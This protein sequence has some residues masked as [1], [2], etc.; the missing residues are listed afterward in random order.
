MHFEHTEHVLWTQVW[1]NT[2]QFIF[3]EAFKQTCFIWLLT[4]HLRHGTGSD[5]I[6]RKRTGKTDPRELKAKN[7]NTWASAYG[8]TLTV[9]PL[10][11]KTILY[12]LVHS[13]SITLLNQ[14]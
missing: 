2:R 10:Q 5:H 13:K 14:R 12:P 1:L 4:E 7:R 6:Q 3:T 9:I 8:N 11:I